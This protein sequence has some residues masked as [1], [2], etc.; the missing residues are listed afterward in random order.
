MADKDRL[1]LI[2]HGA[3]VLLVGLLSGLP[4]AVEA[5]DES[6]RFWHI[7]HEALIM[8]GVWMLAASSVRSALVLDTRESSVFVWSFLVMGYGFMI[9]LV[10]GGVLGVSPF[11]PGGTPATFVAFLS[12]VLGIL[13]AFTAT[14]VTLI[15][16][17]AARDSRV[18]GPPS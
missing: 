12:A 7:A 18:A 14:A 4:T 3:I 13:G 9:A 17:R 11:S 2:F 6:A 16:V 1:R 15:G 10:M 8:M 5:I